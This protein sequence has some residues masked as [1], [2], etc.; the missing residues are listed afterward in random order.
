MRKGLANTIGKWLILIALL[1][2]AAVMAVWAMQCDSQARCT[3]IEV[4]ITARSFMGDTITQRGVIAEL[5]RFDK[6]I[7]GKRLSAI[8]TR[9]IE[10]FLSS[11]NNFEDVQ[12]VVTSGGKLR[13]TVVPVVP[14]IRVFD[15][16]DS[17]YINKDGKRIDANARFF[18]NVPI[19]TGHFTKDFPASSLLPVTRRIAADSTFK[20]L[21]MMVKADSPN[22]ILLIPR[23][24]GH[25]INIGDSRNLDTKLHN[26]LLAYRDI[27]P[28]QGWEKYDTISVKFDGRIVA[29]RRDKSTL[30][31][32]PEFE[33]SIDFDADA[34]DAID[35]GTETAAA[36]MDSTLKIA[37]KPKKGDK[38]NKG[39]STDNKPPKPKN[40]QT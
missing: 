4:G 7:I 37:K 14:E 13:I 31:H 10:K 6:N 22:D 12:C 24:A 30:S 32:T 34:N 16:A 3:G 19:V 5:A 28:Y 1:S 29:S 39:G 26:V 25:V 21:V 27:M 36:A 2:Y 33:E 35:A 40:T 18:C 15:G 9:S 38:K 20:H 23:V 17:Y 11:F 8:N